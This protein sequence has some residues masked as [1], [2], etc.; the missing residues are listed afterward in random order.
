MNHY[1]NTGPSGL[2]VVSEF[3]L[4]NRTSTARLTP[5]GD[6]IPSLPVHL[7][8]SIALFLSISAAAQAIEHGTINISND[9][10]TLT[11]LPSASPGASL[12]AGSSPGDYAIGIDPPGS[13]NDGLVISSVAENDRDTPCRFGYGWRAILFD[14][15]LDH[16]D[17]IH[18][19]V[20]PP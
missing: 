10:A 4:P 9:G 5:E 15:R 1:S 14:G 6:A 7:R 11:L 2:P 16:H 3:Q 20:S 8:L 13:N 12:A 17:H 18:R 19:A